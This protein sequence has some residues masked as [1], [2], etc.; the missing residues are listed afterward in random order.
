MATGRAADP[1]ADDRDRVLSV[2]SVSSLFF[3]FS[4]WKAH[5]IHRITSRRNRCKLKDYF[6]PLVSVVKDRVINFC[7]FIRLN[8]NK[9]CSEAY[10][11]D[12]DALNT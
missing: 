11:R 6:I 9:A 3:V 8:I 4:L 12:C 2:R 7:S 5:N 10:S 1:Q